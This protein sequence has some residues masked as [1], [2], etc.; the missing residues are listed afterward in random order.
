HLLDQLTHI[1]RTGTRC[2]LVGHGA[3]P[4]DQP[5]FVQ[6]AQRHQHQA[7]GAVA[8]DVVPGARVQRLVDYLAVDRVEYD[9]GVIGHTQR[10]RGVDPV[11]LPA[12]FTQ[13]GEYFA[14][15]VAALAGQDH[16]QAL[17]VVDAVG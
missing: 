10:G 13:L 4:L 2:R 7:D 9:D 6:A 14:G 11:P 1:L 16:V 3:H 15:V 17:E 8:A 12:R 5:G